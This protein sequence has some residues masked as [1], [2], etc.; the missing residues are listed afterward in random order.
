[1][2]PMERPEEAILDGSASVALTSAIEY[3]RNVGVV[4]Y[5]MVPGIALMTR[6]FAGMVRLLFNKHLTSFNSMAVKDPMSPES[7]LMVMILAEKHDIEPRI[8]RVPAGATADEMLAAADCALLVGD[9]AIFEAAGHSSMLDLTDEWEDVVEAPLPYMVAW[10]RL[11]VLTQVSIDEI[12]AAR[13]EAVLTLADRAANHPRTA[14]A[15]AFYQR[16][17]RGEIDYVLN[18]E[19]VRALEAYFQFIF[20]HAAIPDIPAI[21]FLPDGAL[22]G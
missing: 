15:N 22:P 9:D 13:D 18:D 21:K 5:A 10:G 19:G 1:M 6:G 12:N 16:Y 11:G 14:E 2:V 17:L 20:Y 8:V 3:G 7:A 4:E